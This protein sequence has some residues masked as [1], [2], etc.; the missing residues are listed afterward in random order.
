[1]SEQA[2]KRSTRLHL[3]TKV[4]LCVAIAQI[5]IL[6]LAALLHIREVRDDYLST[7]ELRSLAMASPLQKRAADLSGY[8]PEMQRTLGLNIDCQVLLDDN[9]KSGLMYVGVIGV[10]GRVIA[11]T[12]T[13]Q[14]G[15]ML[16]ADTLK[17]MLAS[18]KAL[19]IAGPNAY[20]TMIPVIAKP[21]QPPIAAIEI[22]FSRQV[23]DEKIRDI[24]VY[25]ASL[26]LAFVV[27][28]FVLISWLLKRFVTNPI[29]AL[30]KAAAGLARG[31]QTDN[32]PA[33]GAQ[34]IALLADSFGHMRDAIKQQI[35]DLNREIS[36][37]EEAQDK[38]SQ[39]E[40]DLRVTLDSI[41]DA[42]IATDTDGRVV[43]VNPVAE[44]LTGWNADEA[45]G[46]PLN[47]IFRIITDADRTPMESPVNQ[48][49][50]SGEIVALAKHTILISK[51]GTERQVADSGAPIKSDS[52][53]VIGVVLV[54]RDITAE[55]ALQE[56]LRQS[57]KM[58]AVG[59]LAGGVAHDFNNLLTGI[60]GNAQL[61]EMTLDSESKEAKY[62][63]QID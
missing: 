55:H 30:S 23:V 41:G 43:R 12:D 52:G 35:S 3:G 40:E 59:Q 58:E 1:M 48:V 7:V 2:P 20:H 54:F 39:S 51:N 22:G 56:R 46:Q 37:R 4:T 5:P 26:F 53:E 49:L 60:L 61:L 47:N 8:S 36:R 9:L 6:A 16:H 21:G 38:L 44:K 14:W 27:L 17:K 45:I 18:P 50:S 34:E 62:A 28:S 15:Q 13:R 57:Q 25:A 63:S 32:I 42:V 29:T 10:N 31:S 24:F 19:T 33:G 11:H